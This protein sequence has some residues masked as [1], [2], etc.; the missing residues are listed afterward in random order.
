MPGVWHA[1]LRVFILPGP[2]R[3]HV[4]AHSG[5]DAVP[6]VSTLSMPDA[7]S[8]GSKSIQDFPLSGF[9]YMCPGSSCDRHGQ[10]G[11]PDGA[12]YRDAAFFRALPITI[13]AA[14]SVYFQQIL[15]DDNVEQ[16]SASRRLSPAFS[17]SK[18]F[19]QAT[20]NTFMQ[21]IFIL[22]FEYCCLAVARPAVRL[23][24]SHPRYLLVDYSDYLPLAEQAFTNAV[25]SWLLSGLY[26]KLSRDRPGPARRRGPRG[27]GPGDR[28]GR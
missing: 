9:L 18:P 23:S 8:G 27:P 10:A 5:V 2:P 12:R 4:A 17:A 24:C 25:V 13:W 3:G 7:N 14:F 26:R 20:A 19:S 28:Q 6:V 16:R 1:G 15:Q 11:R 22:Q 21:A